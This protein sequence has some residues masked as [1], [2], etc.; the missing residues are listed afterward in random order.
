VQFQK[1]H[2]GQVAKV[3]AAVLAG[4]VVIVGWSLP[5]LTAGASAKPRSTPA[6]VTVVA[7]PNLT[8]DQ[9]EYV[10]PAGRIQL[11]IDG[12]PGI[13]VGFADRR[14][15]KCVLA[16]DGQRTCQVQLRPGRYTIWDT[17]PGHRTG[18]HGGLISTI[19]ATP[20]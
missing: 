19:V 9:K 2:H 12:V 16:M 7:K 10:V 3:R 1:R 13:A 14:I 15:S 5:T 8:F 18:S 11:R 4:I 20:R 6:V 17:I